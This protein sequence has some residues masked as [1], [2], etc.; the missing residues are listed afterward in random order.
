MRREDIHQIPIQ[1]LLILSQWSGGVTLRVGWIQANAVEHIADKM[2]WKSLIA[3]LE[4]VEDT[5]EI[6]TINQEPQSVW[7]SLPEI[8]SSVF[9]GTTEQQVLLCMLIKNIVSTSVFYAC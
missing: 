1:H 4:F 9:C 8:F 5:Q 7:N 6:P 3:I 2:D